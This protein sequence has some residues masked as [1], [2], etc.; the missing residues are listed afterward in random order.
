MW[1]QIAINLAIAAISLLLYKPPPGPASRT[2]EDLNVPKSN[3]GDAI[4]DIAGTAW[5]DDAHVVWY[6]DFASKPIYKRGGKK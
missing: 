3:E 1:W 6:G 2:V 5:V 4:Y